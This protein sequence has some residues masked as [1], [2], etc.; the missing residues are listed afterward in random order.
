MPS[1]KDNKQ[2]HS[3]SSSDSEWLPDEDNASKLGIQRIMHDMFPSSAGKKRL[4]ALEK[5]ELLKSKFD[6]KDIMSRLRV[7]A[8][9]ED[10]ESEYDDDENTVQNMKFNITISVGEGE[11]D[12]T[13]YEFET[14]EGEYEEEDDYEEDDYEEDEHEEDE[15]E[16][17]DYEYG[18]EREKADKCE[19]QVCGHALSKTL[20]FFAGD[21]QGQQELSVGGKACGASFGFEGPSRGTDI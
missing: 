11:E 1:K 14:C 3:D 2:H 12:D 5:L 10:M 7:R 20:L 13:V 9:S 15:H 19:R 21:A 18:S 6:K 16:E 4:E 17:D 8:R